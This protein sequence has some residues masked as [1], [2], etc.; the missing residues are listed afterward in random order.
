MKYCPPEMKIVEFSCEDVIRVSN[1][2]IILPFIPISDDEPV[3]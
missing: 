3:D 1:G 2:V